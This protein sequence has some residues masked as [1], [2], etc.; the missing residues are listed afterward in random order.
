MDDHLTVT[1]ENQG[2]TTEAVFYHQW[3]EW[4]Y[5]GDYD[6]EDTPN[7][8]AAGDEYDW[9][10]LVTIIIMVCVLCLVGEKIVKMM[11]RTVQFLKQ[12]RRVWKWNQLAALDEDMNEANV[13]PDNNHDQEED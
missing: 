3:N 11:K 6:H 8:Y 10:L 2:L 12:A 4:S 13:E 9:E 1:T 5:S 7:E